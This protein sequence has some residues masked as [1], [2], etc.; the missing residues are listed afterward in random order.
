MSSTSDGKAA[1]R[2][3]AQ[4]LKETGH[5]IIAMNWR[6]RWCEI[7]IVSSK[8]KVI[9]FTEVKYRSSDLQ[10]SGLEYITK[11]KLQQINFAAEFWISQE[12]WEGEV[13]LLGAEVDGK[14][15][16]TFVEI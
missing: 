7:D 11:K 2:A 1:E 12:K 14:Y 6:T 10:G 9:Y 3:V 13:Q 8:Q 16:I 4:R 5:K 15:A